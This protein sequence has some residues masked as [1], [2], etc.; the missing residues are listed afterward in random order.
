[1]LKFLSGRKRSRNALLLLFVGILALSLVGLFS[2]AVSGGAAGL[3]RGASG[4]DTVIAKVGSYDITVKEFK[5][6][7][8]AFG[9]QISQGQGRQGAMDPKTTYDLYGKQVLDSLIR[10]KLMLYE[11][12]R[13]ALGAAD[14]EVQSRIRQT[15]NPW[16]GPE[17]YRARLQ[18]AGFTPVRFEDD[19]RAAIGQEH[20]RSFI[21][22]AVQVDPKEV[23]KEYIKTKTNYTVRWV[24]VTPEQLR[25]KVQVNDADLRAFFEQNKNDFKI[26]SEQRHAR[27]IFIDQNKAGEAIQV[28]DEEL[29]Q[30]FT[31]DANIKQVRVS[32]IVLNVPKPEPAKPNATADKPADN[33]KDKS[34][35]EAPKKPTEEDIRKK[36][37]DLQQ[38]AAGKDGKPA[39]DFAKLVRENSDDIK[40]KA[41]G[42]DLGWINK[43]AKR[44]GDDPLNR[45]FSMQKDQVSDP[46]RK[47]DKWY[48]LK[49]TDRRLPTFAEARAD[50]LKSARA[51]KG[52]SKA[53]EIAK[54]AESKFKE[55]KNAE[56]TVAEID[57]KYGAQVATVKETPYFSE[58]DSV[59]E[60]GPSATF[61]TAVFEL[62]NPNDVADEVSIDKGFAIAQLIDKRDPHDAAFEEVKSKVEQRYRSDKAK[63]LASERAKQIAKGKTPDEMK[64]IADG[65][66]L[67]VEERA[68]F[69][70]ADSIGPLVSDE[71]REPV[72]KLNVGEVTSEPIKSESGDSYVVVGL[73]ARKDA[74]MGDKYKTE[75]KSIEQRLMD[76]KRNTY[77]TTYLDTTMKQMKSDGKIRIYQDR[78]DSAME[79]TAASRAPQPGGMPGMPS[80]P[81]QRRTPSGPAPR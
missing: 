18:Q 80:K 61:E 20:L 55:N 16:P 70:G 59:P 21:T 43:D 38:R 51:E 40:T 10:Q 47:G 58:S 7:L 73:V 81:R 56:A 31:P 69:S 12:D 37:Q 46:I 4:S 65:F 11:A 19:L 63:D 67:R 5:D 78:I 57:K 30:R 76:E 36:A 62:E 32:Q 8:A 14:S 9:Q 34:K 77:F 64:K 41:A 17:Q 53:V 25:D 66:G 27:Y 48:I 54:E 79:A 52:Y 42:G 60:I 50:L 74:D 6:S 22:A 75:S 26:A 39:E 71:S 13:L 23:E 1:M 68:N 3:F 72:Y 28:P 29:K 33:E 49:V 15:F 45:V 44:D 35:P 2:V 24:D